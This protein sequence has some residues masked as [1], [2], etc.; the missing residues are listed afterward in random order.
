[1]KVKRILNNSLDF[2]TQK[3]HATR[4]KALFS[5]V[6]SLLYG[7]HATVTSIGRDISSKAN[8]K[9]RIKQADRLLSNKKL[10]ND[11]LNIY[12]RFAQM[13]IPSGSRPLIL[14]DWSD[15]DKGRRNFLIRA[16]LVCESKRG[17]PI[18]EEVH[19]KNTKEKPHSHQKFIDK[20]AQV[21]P[22]NCKPIIVTD[23]GFRVPW[24]KQIQALGWDF[25]GRTRLPN[26]YSLNGEV[27]N[28]LTELYTKATLRPKTFSG[29]ITQSNPLAV[30]MTLYKE[31]AKGRKDL[32]CF[33][34]PRQNSNSRQHAD[35]ATDPWLITTSLPMKSNLGKK[36]VNIYKTRMQIE[37][38][39][40]DMKCVR[41]GQSMSLHSS[42]KTERL[43][44]LV[45]LTTLA[46]WVNYLCGTI[47]IQLQ[48]QYKYQANTIK[49]RKVLSVIYLGKRLLKD[50]HSRVTTKHIVDALSLIPI[51]LKT[52]MEALI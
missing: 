14:I 12:R 42:Y 37:E 21:I 41:T 24:F 47:V 23:A 22:E 40:K 38:G 45:L 1:M 25:V 2:V 20:L 13:L 11:A 19:G 52:V 5:C 50:R 36:L 29:Y 3:M 8:E 49:N 9:H 16:S 33:G 39:F 15:L 32:N 43:S 18:Y 51:K 35:S 46:N 27:W 34:K 17:I 10:N 6:E 48:N 30:N 31:R 44:N 28:G 4:K 26:M 7:A